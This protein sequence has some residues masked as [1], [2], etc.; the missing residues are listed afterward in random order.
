MQL[1]C[2]SV[3][4][5]VSFYAFSRFEAEAIRFSGPISSTISVFLVVIR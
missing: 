2:I 5:S 1:L 3:Q 4:K